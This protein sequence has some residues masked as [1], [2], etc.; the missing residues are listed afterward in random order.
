MPVKWRRYAKRRDLV[1]EAV[2]DARWARGSLNQQAL[3][4]DRAFE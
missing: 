4:H 3:S 1:R 2:R